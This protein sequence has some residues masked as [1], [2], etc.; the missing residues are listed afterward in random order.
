M[1]RDPSRVRTI[2]G[3]AVLVRHMKGH[4][5]VGSQHLIAWR[6]PKHMGKA[7]PV[8]AVWRLTPASCQICHGWQEIRAPNMGLRR[9]VLGNTG[10]R[11]HKRHPESSFHGVPFPPAQRLIEALL[12]L[13][14]A[15]NVGNAPVVGQVNHV[16][17]V[18]QP[19]FIHL[20]Q[21]LAKARIQIHGHAGHSLVT[22]SLS[23]FRRLHFI[24]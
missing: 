20:R 23:G 12:V 10:T 1:A 9:H 6:S 7:P 18:I 21:K 13:L 24:E 15:R 3:D 11:H 19:Q 4:A 2:E 8:Q 17:V 16:G 5:R 14:G 22:M